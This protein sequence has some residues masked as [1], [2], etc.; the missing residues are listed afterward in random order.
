MQVFL[1]VKSVCILNSNVL[2][3]AVHAKYYLHWFVFSPQSWRP[4]IYN[5]YVF[6]HI[7][8]PLLSWRYWHHL[9]KC[10]YS[11]IRLHSVKVKHF[12]IHHGENP[13]S[14][15]KSFVQ[16][17]APRNFALTEFSMSKFEAAETFLNQLPFIDG[18]YPQFSHCHQ[19]RY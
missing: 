11:P 13:I 1:T 15:K 7:R 12:H 4:F 19:N 16:T 2:R 9:L 6:C 18:I 10:Q 5:K 3:S 8:L 17:Q 14:R